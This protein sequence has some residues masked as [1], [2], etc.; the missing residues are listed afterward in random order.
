MSESIMHG[1]N[2][3]NIPVKLFHTLFIPIYVLDA[4]LQNSGGS[5]PQKLEPRSRIGMYL[6]HS[7][8]HAGSVALVWNPTTVRVSSQYHVVFDDKFSTVPKMEAGNIPTN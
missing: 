3:E 5:G 7:P 6:G 2:G 4:R 1:V 8:L